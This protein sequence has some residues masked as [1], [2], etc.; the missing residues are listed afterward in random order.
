LEVRGR[1]D[2]LSRLRDRYRWNAVE[3]NRPLF[4]VFRGAIVSD[5]AGAGDP[6]A[7]DT[8]A[9]AA[10]VQRFLLVW[11]ESLRAWREGDCGLSH[12]PRW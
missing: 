6:A 3:M 8:T 4:A 7:G 5:T 10:M 1:P 11:P 2:A 9:P 12:P